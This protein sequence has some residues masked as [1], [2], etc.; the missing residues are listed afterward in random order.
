MTRSR[1]GSRSVPTWSSSRSRGC[2]R[3]RPTWSRRRT[4]S[5]TPPSVPREPPGPA[6]Q[7]AAHA[8]RHR[9][10]RA[11][12]DRARLARGALVRARLDDRSVRADPRALRRAHHA[13]RDRNPGD[14]ARTALDGKGVG[15]GRGRDRPRR[16]ASAG[17]CLAAPS[18]RSV[19]R[20]L[21]Q[22]VRGLLEPRLLRPDGLPVPGAGRPG[23]RSGS[24]L[25]SVGVRRREGLRHLG[26]ALGGL[27]P[28]GRPRALHPLH[29]PVAVR[30]G[31]HRPVRATA[32]RVVGRHRE[33]CAGH[34]DRGPRHPPAGIGFAGGRGRTD[35]RLDPRAA[36]CAIGRPDRPRGQVR[37]ASRRAFREGPPAGQWALAG[38]RRARAG[39][40]DRRGHDRGGAGLALDRGRV[41]C[42]GARGRGRG[43]E[44]DAE[45]RGPASGHEPRPRGASRS[46]GRWLR[47]SGRSPDG[48]RRRSDSP[49]SRCSVTSSGGSS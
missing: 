9:D 15:R 10:P 30:R 46:L 12:P 2:G 3:R 29:V 4:P 28:Q 8:A 7:P 18:A 20:I 39:L 33:R 27:P 1:T 14:L 35:G 38:R 11:A 40:R 36:G 5:R 19:R 13:R 21:Q 37:G 25:Q 42:G 32:G 44:A 34:V 41:R 43:F 6:R 31:V 17:R 47:V 48:R 22:P 23:C 49:R 16:G 24:H 45:G 26:G